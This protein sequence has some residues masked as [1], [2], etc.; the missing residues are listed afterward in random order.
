MGPLLKYGLTLGATALLLGAAS[1]VCAEGDRNQLFFGIDTAYVDSST[2]LTA[3]PDGGT[4]KLR[5]VGDGVKN[6]RLFAEYHGRITPTLNAR[7]V[8][9]YLD[10]GSSGLGLDEA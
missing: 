9:D 5:F 1:R 3:W 6:A 10:D 8:A 4:G 7:V 2:K